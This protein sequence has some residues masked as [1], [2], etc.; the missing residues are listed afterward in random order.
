MG[1]HIG[2]TWQIQLNHLCSRDAAFLL[3]YFDHLLI[4][5]AGKKREIELKTCWNKNLLAWTGL[6]KGQLIWQLEECLQ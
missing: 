3:N 6:T 1:V 4:V 5:T 2:A